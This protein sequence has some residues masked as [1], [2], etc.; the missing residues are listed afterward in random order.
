M[1]ILTFI[2]IL[3]M[4]GLGAAVIFPRLAPRDGRPVRLHT[5]TP[6]DL[7]WLVRAEGHVESQHEASLAF[8][9][10][11]R[12][13]AVEVKR[14]DLVK[15]GDVIAR[16]DTSETRL[17]E[18][19]A[20]LALEAARVT[21]A[22]LE[23]GSRTEEIEEARARVAGAKS[24]LEQARRD[25]EKS[26]KLFEQSALDR[27]S[28]EHDEMRVDTEQSALEALQKRL[29]LLE[30]GPRPEEI[31]RASIAVSRAEVRLEEIRNELE[32]AVLRAPSAG[33]ITIR[34]LDPGEMADAEHPVVTLTD[35][36]HLEAVL[37]VDEFDAGSLRPGLPVDITTRALP[38][39]VFKSEI[40]EV[41]H[42][43]GRRGMR[44]DDPTVIYDSRVIETRVKLEADPRLRP[45]MT[46]DGVIT[47]V[48]KKQ[49]PFVPI[50]AVSADEQGRPCV[51]IAATEDTPGAWRLVELGARD[52]RDVEVLSGLK[53]GETV[54][55]PAPKR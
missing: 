52:R 23:A 7:E 8:E 15:K 51:R 31:S 13:V 21:L 22:E 36:A 54:T 17:L 14:A 45:G 50:R 5:V 37:D 41:S 43:V 35:T 16:L 55:V 39:V 34:H 44:G 30:A 26:R 4:L 3:A 27:Q 11:G 20:R 19:G 9:R 24:R 6:G 32:K 53:V 18:K 12:I 40:T 38:G 28:L 2:L 42:V 10:P 29:R 25:L 49:V 1:R 33:R 48:R 47:V 46:V